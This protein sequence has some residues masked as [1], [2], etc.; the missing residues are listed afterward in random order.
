MALEQKKYVEELAD[1]LTRIADEAQARL[2]AAI[3]NG[4]TN[5]TDARSAFDQIA[6]LR[7]NANSMYVDTAA[8]IV[9]DLNISQHELTQTIAL[10]GIV[11][12]NIQQVGALIELLTDFVKLSAAASAGKSKATFDQIKKI[13][14][15]IEELAKI[16]AKLASQIDALGASGPA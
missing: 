14:H 8:A 2:L 7:Q 4:E 5:P 15:D 12:T 9:Q 10:G 13:R 11:I 6:L 3:R 1:H 16:D